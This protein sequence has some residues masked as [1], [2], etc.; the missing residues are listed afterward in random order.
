[1]N[2]SGVELSQCPAAFMA[3]CANIWTAKPVNDL[4]VKKQICQCSM[5][6][7]VRLV[8]S[9][10]YLR[11]VDQGGGDFDSLYLYQ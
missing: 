1:M 2:Q 8:T 10:R 4:Y 3:A 6:D 5:L 7:Y 11:R 9:D